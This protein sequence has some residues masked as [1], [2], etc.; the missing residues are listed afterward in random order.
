M[1]G[2]DR[3]SRRGNLAAT[4]LGSVVGDVLDAHLLEVSAPREQLQERDGRV[5][6][7][8]VGTQYLQQRRID[9]ERL[10]RIDAIDRVVLDPQ[11]QT[12]RVETRIRGCARM[13]APRLR[14]RLCPKAALLRPARRGVESVAAS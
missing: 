4:R 11:E 5:E 12:M 1:C 10:S 14:D 3:L 13:G 6:G 9:V 8:A 7:A 2:K